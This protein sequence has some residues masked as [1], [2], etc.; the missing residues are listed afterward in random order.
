MTLRHLPIHTGCLAEQAAAKFGETLALVGERPWSFAELAAAVRKVATGLAHG[1]VEPGDRVTLHGENSWQWVVGYHGALRAGAVVNPL[2]VM[3]TSDEIGEIAADCGASAAIIGSELRGKFSTLPS[4]TLF[5]YQDIERFCGEGIEDPPKVAPGDLAAIC[6]TSGTTGR[7][8]GAKHSHRAVLHNIALTALMHGKG[9]GD[10]VVTAL[11][12]P[13][14]YGNVVMNAGFVTGSSLDLHA[15]FDPGAVLDSIESGA[16]MFEG[17]PTMYAYLL[18]EEL[19]VRDLSSL[20]ICTVGGQT[21]PTAT[22][23]AV[24]Q[25]LG[26]PL[27]ELWGMT[28]LAGLG[29]THP[30]TGPRKLGSIGTSLPFC[31]AR[32]DGGYPGPGELL[33]RGPVVMDGYWGN[34]AATREAIL[35]DGWL[36]TGDIATRDEDGFIFIVDRAKD[37]ILT[38]GFNVYPAELERVIAMHEAVSLVAVAGLPD[39]VKGEIAAAWIVPKP[40]MTLTEH[41][42]AAHCR[43]RLAAYKQPRR[44]V[45]VD[46][47]PRTSTGK[48]LRRALPATLEIY[49]D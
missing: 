45:F 9:P 3:L 39:P 11:P 44:Y 40:G 8:K 33:V 16:T 13:H 49:H 38:A 6:Y 19:E 15:R 4:I 36:R 27:I 28:E 31:E 22:M 37:M 42:I 47:L 32:I 46:D 1:G 35:E 12:C 41:E 23:E 14:V 26:C 7:S 29:T 30:W 20:R 5:D 48:I 17:V 34:E 18:N 25:R 21:M 24:E 2:N 10:R 43:E